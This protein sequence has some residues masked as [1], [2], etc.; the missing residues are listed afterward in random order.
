VVDKALVPDLTDKLRPKGILMAILGVVLGGACGI[1]WVL[2]RRYF[3]G[4]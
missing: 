1:A 3:S 4:A 2:G